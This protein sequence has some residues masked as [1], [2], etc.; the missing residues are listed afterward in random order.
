MGDAVFEYVAQGNSPPVGI[1]TAAN[2]G[3]STVMDDIAAAGDVDTTVIL[4]RPFV[5][6]Q[7]SASVEVGQS[8]VLMTFK[9]SPIIERVLFQAS[10]DRLAFIQEVLSQWAAIPVALGKPIQPET[11]WS[12]RQ[13]QAATQSDRDAINEID[14]APDVQTRTILRE[15]LIQ[16]LRSPTVRVNEIVMF[17][18]FPQTTDAFRVYVASTLDF[19]QFVQHFVVPLA[20]AEAIGRSA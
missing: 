12:D 1:F 5:V 10:L 15:P 4:N 6:E 20:T 7:V 2:A 8:F 18:N 3:Q 19:M 11:R 13:F 9:S 17:I 16:Y 14:A